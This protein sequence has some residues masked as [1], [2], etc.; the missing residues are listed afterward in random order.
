MA[1]FN[2]FNF[3]YSSSATVYGVPEKIPIPESTR[4]SPESVYG[5]TK[6][7]T[8]LIIKDICDSNPAWRAISLRYFNPAGAH[9]S[10][11]IGESPVGRPGNLLPLLSAIAAGRFSSEP[12]KINGNDYPTEDGACIRDYIHVRT[13][14]HLL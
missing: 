11:L 9:P 12:L 14:N 10:G 6:Y 1:R 3:V 4:L 5:R 7:M 2:C 13:S 8:E